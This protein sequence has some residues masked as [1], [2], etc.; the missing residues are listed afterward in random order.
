M[1]TSTYPNLLTHGIDSAGDVGAPFELYAGDTPQ[2]AHDQGQAADGQAI[3]QFEVLMH[4]ASGRLV[5]LTTAGDYATGTI[6]VGGQPADTETVTINGEAITFIAAGVPTAT[7]VLIGADTTE[8]ATRLREVINSDPDLYD[9]VASGTG[10]TVTLT[11]IA[12]GTAGNAITLAEAVADV[13]FTVSGATLTGA[14]AAEDV[15]SG[16]AVAIALQAV[17]A[18]TPGA[19]VPVAVAGCFN[20]E[21]LV[22]PA[23][24]GT[25]RQRK[26]A[27][28][29]SRGIVVKQLL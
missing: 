8:T 17:P 27:F 16:N 18:A 26:M 28:E 22:W 6:T 23:G 25:L 9:V 29:S 10:T 5:P 19:Y 14:N 3:Q 1:A 21:A 13:G 7:Q 20:H 24:L 12:A 2:P 11:A 4:N 15:P